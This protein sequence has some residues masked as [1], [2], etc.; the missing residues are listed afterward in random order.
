LSLDE[1]KTEL[2]KVLFP[3]FVCLFLNMILKS[4]KEEANEFFH[5]HKG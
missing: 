4:F 3:V 1:V 5:K 2:S